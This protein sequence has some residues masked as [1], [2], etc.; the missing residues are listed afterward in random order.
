[1]GNCL[2]GYFENEKAQETGISKDASLHLASQ[3]IIK[4]L[5]SEKYH[6]SKHHLGKD[7]LGYYPF[8]A[9]GA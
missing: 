6:V 3:L 2:L 1:M 7:I 4:K 8:K 5:I 9:P